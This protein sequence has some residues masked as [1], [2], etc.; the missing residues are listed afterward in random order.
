LPGAFTNGWWF[1]ILA[2]ADDF[3]HQ[4]LALIVDASLSNQSLCRA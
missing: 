1:R 4:R 2:I 3:I